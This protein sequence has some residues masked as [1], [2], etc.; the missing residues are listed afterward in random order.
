MHL[1]E[2][3]TELRRMRE[4][5]GISQE[6]LALLRESAIGLN[7][8][9]VVYNDEHGASLAPVVHFFTDIINN[10]PED[11]FPYRLSSVRPTKHIRQ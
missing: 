5:L 3:G 6:D 4:R 2:V 7:S 8:F 11:K 9:T 10:D 1:R